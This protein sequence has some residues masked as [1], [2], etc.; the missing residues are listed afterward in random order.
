MKVLL[1]VV[2][3]VVSTYCSL[4]NVADKRQNMLSGGNDT[5]YGL[6]VLQIKHKV[7]N[8]S[9]ML[10]FKFKLQPTRGV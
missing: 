4:L 3:F 9:M 8:P 5:Q 2:C 10:E 7:I 6:K 1:S